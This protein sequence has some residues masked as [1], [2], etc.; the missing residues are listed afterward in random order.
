MTKRAIEEDLNEE[1]KKTWKR[2][3]SDSG[4]DCDMLDFKASAR[5]FFK[6][7]LPE[8]ERTASP[9]THPT[10]NDHPFAELAPTYGDLYSPDEA[11]LR[12]DGPN[13]NEAPNTAVTVSQGASFVVA[14]S[15]ATTGPDMSSTATGPAP[16]CIERRPMTAQEREQHYNWGSNAHEQIPP[17]GPRSL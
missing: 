16:G 4:D 9:S 13:T 7:K 17:G 5:R 6:A 2:L 14:T 15:Q 12:E 8:S 1:D 3:Q 11:T 10:Q